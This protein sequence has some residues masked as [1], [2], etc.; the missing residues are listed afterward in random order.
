M[1]ELKDW[2]IQK[3]N[4]VYDRRNRVNDLTGKEWLFST[5]SVKTKKFNYFYDVLTLLEL[6]FIDFMP[7][8]LISELIVTFSKSDALIID[9]ISNFGSIGYAT[10]NIE[11]NREYFGFKYLE[12]IKIQFLQE[13]QLKNINFFKDALFNHIDELS[14]Y[15]NCIL[16]SELIYSTLENVSRSGQLRQFEDELKKSL[17]TLTKNEI[18]LNYVI[19][20]IQNTKEYLKYQFNTKIIFNL[21]NSMNF[22]LKSELIWKIHE[23]DFKIIRAYLLSNLQNKSE[24]D[25]LLNDKRILIFK[26]E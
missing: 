2:Q 1:S 14:R 18:N 22:N 3:E 15:K 21:L 8:E 12:G 6:N 13:F 17:E 16:F 7:I 23:N 11:S 26:R 4:G 20:A 25:A 10:S 9:P 5:R 19:I 24:I